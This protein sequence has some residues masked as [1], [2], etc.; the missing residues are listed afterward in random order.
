V[1]RANEYVFASYGEKTPHITSA[2]ATFKA[3]SKIAGLPIS[4]HDLRRTFE[5][6]A[7]ECKIDS[8]QRR[9]LINHI[10]GDVHAVHYANN[11]RALAGAVE[12]IATWVLTQAKI[13]D[14]ANVVPLP[15][16]LAG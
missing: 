8:D 2:P 5:D 6:I 11:R 4:R 16:K 3:I 7:T 9:L 12:V 13:A 1:Q 10:T 14:S 15:A